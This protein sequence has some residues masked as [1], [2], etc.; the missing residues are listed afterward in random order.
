[1]HNNLHSGQKEG[2]FQAQIMV[3]RN[4]DVAKPEN[5]WTNPNELR[6]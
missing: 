5:S 4:K 6:N 1:M 3:L 2:G